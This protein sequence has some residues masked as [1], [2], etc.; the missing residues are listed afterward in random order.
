MGPKLRTARLYFTIVNNCTLFLLLFFL[1]SRSKD[2]GPRVAATANL[3][4][5]ESE[6]RVLKSFSVI[7]AI[8]EIFYN[9]VKVVGIHYGALSL[10]YR[11]IILQCI[12]VY[13]VGKTVTNPSRE[14]NALKALNRFCF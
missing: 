12:E 7:S 5:T 11:S 1:R 6:P 13:C 9:V 2:G 3:S 8:S 10:P 4:G 14:H